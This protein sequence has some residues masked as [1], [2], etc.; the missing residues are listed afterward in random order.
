MT[1]DGQ[2]LRFQEITKKSARDT[3]LAPLLL[4]E[5]RQ[6]TPPADHPWKK[7]FLSREEDGN[8]LSL[9]LKKQDISIL[10]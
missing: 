6:W 9:L 8:S 4:H 1:C 5:E 3:S 2:G 7:I 10:A